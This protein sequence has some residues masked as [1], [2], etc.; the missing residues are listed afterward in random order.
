MRLLTT[1]Q[2]PS[3][4]WCTRLNLNREVRFHLQLPGSGLCEVDYPHLYPSPPKDL[5]E[6]HN[7]ASSPSTVLS[8]PLLNGGTHFRDREILQTAW[9]LY[10]AEIGLKRIM[11]NLL[12]W[13]CNITSGRD[14]LDQETKDHILQQNMMEF[15]KQIQEWSVTPK[16]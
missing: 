5:P 10:L 4:K 9:Y 11:N 8:W 16:K 7:Q 3:R 6:D 15:D 13:R 14:I 1:F 12:L 2:L